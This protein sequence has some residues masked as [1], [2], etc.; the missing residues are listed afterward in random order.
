[1]GDGGDEEPGGTFQ[2]SVGSFPAI[3][4]ERLL[5]GAAD[6][7][8]IEIGVIRWILWKFFRNKVE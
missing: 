8:E 7:T 1:M 5:K 4:A 2:D 3:G 6:F